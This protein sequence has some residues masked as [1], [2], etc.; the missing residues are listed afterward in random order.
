MYD[1]IWQRHGTMA[2]TA[3]VRIARLER[4]AAWHRF[5]ASHADSEWVWEARLLAA[6]QLERTAAELGRACSAAAHNAACPANRS[7]T[8]HSWFGIA[9]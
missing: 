8:K 6:E 3:A 4:L 9:A 1:E 2:D 5:N 7:L